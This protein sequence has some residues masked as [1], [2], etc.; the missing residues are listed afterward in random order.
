MRRRRRRHQGE[1]NGSGSALHGQHLFTTEGTEG[2]E[3]AVP[4]CPPCPLWF[5]LFRAGAKNYL[6]WQPETSPSSRPAHPSPSAST[7]SV[8]RPRPTPHFPSRRA[9]RKEGF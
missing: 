3:E 8:G 6:A 9:S 2:T 1:P 5:Y 4:P 7:R